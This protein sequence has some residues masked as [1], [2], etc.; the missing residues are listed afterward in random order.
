[1]RD[2]PRGRRH[3]RGRQAGR[4]RSAPQP[5][6]GGADRRRRAARPPDTGSRPAGPTSGRAIV[7]RLDVGTQRSDG[8]RQERAGLHRAQGRVPRAHRGQALPRPRA[9]APRPDDRHGRRAD[10]PAPDVGVQVRRR[11]G[12][13]ATA[14]PTTTRSRR[15]G[16][17]T[18]L[19]IKLETGRTHQIRVHMAALQHPCVGDLHVRRRPHAGRA[20]RPRRQWLHAVRL[21]FAHPARRPRVEF[22]SPYAPDLQA[23]LDRSRPRREDPDR[24]STAGSQP[25]C[26]RR[27]R[28]CGRAAR[29]VD[30]DS[31]PEATDGARP[32]AES[33]TSGTVGTAPAGVRARDPADRVHRHRRGAARRD[34]APRWCG[35]R[36]RSRGHVLREPTGPCSGPRGSVPRIGRP[37]LATTALGGRPGAA[38][39]RAVQH[40]GWPCAA[41][42]AAT[43]RRTR[44]QRLLAGLQVRRVFLRAPDGARTRGSPRSTSGAD[45]RPTC[46]P[47]TPTWCATASKSGRATWRTSRR[48]TTTSPT[49]PTTMPTPT[50]QS[51]R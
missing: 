6:L 11:R 34:R 27:R 46:A 12:R 13:P 41:P 5:R 31:G 32:A 21:S 15:S 50:A 16:H 30:A 19:D 44:S 25:T 3:R 14:S 40:P 37:L 22:T 10:R 18:L 48:P 49:R 47:A 51:G 20:A 26:P 24:A 38:S 9:G 4:C 8:R 36:R 39:A 17:A 1:M 28:G 43:G 33:S 2:R 42:S 35:T 45:L 7:H 23:A 29:L